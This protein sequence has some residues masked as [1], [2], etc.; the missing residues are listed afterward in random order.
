MCVAESNFEMRSKATS[1]RFQNGDTLFARITPCLENG[2]TAFVGIL[3]E[4]EVACGSSEF[5]V[6]REAKISRYAVYL[7]SRLENFRENAIKSMIG[8]SGRQRVQPSA[9]DKYQVCVPPER[10]SE[11]FDAEVEPLF[12]SIH[13]LDRQNQYLAKARDFLLPRLMSGAIAV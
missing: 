5:I 11:N 8:S 12:R 13:L 9:F 10:V 7:L 2:K 1:V 3:G 4:N 6:M